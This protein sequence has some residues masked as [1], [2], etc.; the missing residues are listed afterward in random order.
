MTRLGPDICSQIV[1]PCGTL[2]LMVPAFT[3]ARQVKRHRLPWLSWGLTFSLNEEALLERI[4][5]TAT[6]NCKMAPV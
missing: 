5:S 1:V 2:C 6:L 4:S 3:V